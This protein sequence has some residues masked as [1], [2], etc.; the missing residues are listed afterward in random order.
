MDIFWFIT[1]GLFVLIGIAGCFLPVLPGPPIAFAGLWIQQLKAEAPF[2]NQFLWIWA[3]ITVVVTLLDY[4][5]PVYT[6]K[7]FGGSKAG[8]MGCA[9]GLLV[10]LWFGPLGILLGPVIGAFIGELIAN[11]N[12]AHAF[13]AAMGSF[14][15]FLAGTLIKVIA[16]VIMLWH[17]AASW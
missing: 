11:E 8:I 3:G 17:W 2:S 14:I 12:S 4:W 5:V 7:K 6:T 1:G 16:C 10:G 13:R 15:G 9:L